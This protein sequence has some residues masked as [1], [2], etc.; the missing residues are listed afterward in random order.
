M[1]KAKSA[2]AIKDLKFSNI[3]AIIFDKDG[4]LEDSLPFWRE[5][6]I[7]RARLIDAQIP[8]VGEPLLMAFGIQDRTLDPKGL[9][10][11][12]SRQENEIA[13]AAY[14]AETGRSWHE[15]LKIAKEAFLEISESKYLVKTP[16][17]APLFPEVRE[18]LQSLHSAGIKIGILSADSTKE[19]ENFVANHQLQNLVHLSMGVDGEIFKP[20]PRL[21]IQAC[22]A[23]DIN[24]EQTLTIGDSLGDITMA[25]AAGAA[26]TIAIDRRNN[27][28]V[29][30]ADLQ[31]SS[32]SEIQ[33]LSSSS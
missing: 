28:G 21:Y 25:K 7:Q 8:G 27:I 17:S 6:G 31:I 15:S 16:K 14:I 3:S 32:L 5:V 26:G 11:V 9:M 10:A 13:A 12:G 29:L 33:V 22:N 4:T 20:N 30:Q 23:L 19:V 24:P 1:P 2:I 18:V